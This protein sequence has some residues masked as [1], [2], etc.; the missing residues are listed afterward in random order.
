MTE[1]VTESIQA[2]I[3]NV[4][5]L[6]DVLSGIDSSAINAER[7][8]RIK[9]QIAEMQKQLKK[10][11]DFKSTLYENFISG[12]LDKDDYKALKA[13]YSKDE[14]KLND[15]IKTLESELDE[16]V[17]NTSK[18]ALWTEH[19]KQ[20]ENISE[21]DR[22]TLVQLVVSIKIFDKTHLQITYNFEDE[23]EQALSVLENM[24]EAV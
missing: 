20:F 14:Q 17:N 23:Y 6:Q 16:C 24:T 12:I 7:C 3:K 22:N 10:T 21:L 5:S 9:T 18:K 13:T 8:G 1:C 11:A 2:Y 15:T 19:F 4:T